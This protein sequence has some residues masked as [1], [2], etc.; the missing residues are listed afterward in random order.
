ML[1]GGV[2]AFTGLNHFLDAES[3]IGYAD[4]KDVP[5]PGPAVYVSGAVLVLG[6]VGIVGGETWAYAVNA[7][8]F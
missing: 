7:G 2:L 5:A 6:G 3:M 4:A 1:F 8:L